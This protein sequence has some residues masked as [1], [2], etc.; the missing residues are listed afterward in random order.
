LELGGRNTVVFT[1]EVLAVKDEIVATTQK[2]E[3]L[4]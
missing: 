3:E 4:K 1:K 2:L